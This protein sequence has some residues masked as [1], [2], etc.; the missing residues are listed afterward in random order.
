MRVILA[1][2]GAFEALSGEGHVLASFRRACYLLFPR[3]VAALVGPGVHAGPLHAVLDAPPPSLSPG[4]T[5]LMSDGWLL[6]ADCAVPFAGAT[7]WRGRLPSRERFRQVARVVWEV[8]GEAAGRSLV[9]R[10]GGRRDRCLDLILSGDLEGAAALLAGRGPGLTPAGDD[11]LAGVLFAVRA[12]WGPDAEERLVSIAL[13]APTGF[14]ARS[15]LAWAARGQSL[16]PMHDL[17]EAAAI[18]DGLAASR[19]AGAL[20]AVG[21]SSGADMA[22]GLHWGTALVSAPTVPAGQGAVRSRSTAVELA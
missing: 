3:G 9:P 15:L 8:A 22:L 11:A 4:C 6:I 1:G 18:H 21:E 5:A 17:L 7:V 14:V 10:E 20:A 16:A 19:A 2:A 12:A 13:A